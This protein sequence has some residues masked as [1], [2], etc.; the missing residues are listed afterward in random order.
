M[1]YLLLIFQRSFCH[2][3]TG[4]TLN[5]NH[6]SFHHPPQKNRSLLLIMPTEQFSFELNWLK[7]MSLT[8]LFYSKNTVSFTIPFTEPNLDILENL[9]RFIVYYIFSYNGKKLLLQKHNIGCPS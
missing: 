9:L 3:F 7:A 4:L 1:I 6:C 5:C 8:K 2:I